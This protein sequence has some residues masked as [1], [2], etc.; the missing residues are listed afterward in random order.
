MNTCVSAR[1]RVNTCVRA[2]VCA[3]AH[4][5]AAHARWHLRGAGQVARVEG[6]DAVPALRAELLALDDGAVEEGEAEADR[7]ELGLLGRVLEHLVVE[8][9]P[10]ADEVRLQP[11]RRL[12]R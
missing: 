9:R 2:H 8:H 4:A 7:A 5:R 6:V 3:R 10:R 11:L 12:V 1:V